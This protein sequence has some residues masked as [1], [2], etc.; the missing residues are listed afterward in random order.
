[1][2]IRNEGIWV[3]AG[4]RRVYISAVF[5]LNGE[6]KYW[7]STEDKNMTWD[8]LGCCYVRNYDESFWWKRNPSNDLMIWE[9]SEQI[10]PRKIINPIFCLELE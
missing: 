3:T 5:G 7:K 6:V 4:G 8:L 1:M 9:G 2:K 10:P